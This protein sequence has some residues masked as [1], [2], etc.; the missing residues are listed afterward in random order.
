[1][2]KYVFLIFFII[3]LICAIIAYK[4]LNIGNNIIKSDDS[5]ILNISSYEATVEAQIF[6]NKNS[7][8]YI[9]KQKYYEPN[10]FIQE[11][12]EPDNF[13]GFSILYD[14]ENLIIRNDSL[15]VKSTYENYEV[16]SSNSLSLISFIEE[17]K[18]SKEIE[19]KETEEETIIKI[20]INGNNKYEKYKKLYINKKTNLPTKIEV[21]DINENITVYILYKEIKLN[22]TSKEEVLAN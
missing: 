4:L 13:K 3:F 16:L 10:I 2:K 7:N 11:V 6:S 15:E 21:L 17:Y 9:L 19:T 12:I 22:K 5:N 8:K 14:G 20:G 1:M 18:N